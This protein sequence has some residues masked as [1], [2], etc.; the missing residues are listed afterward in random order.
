MSHPIRDHLPL[1][2]RDMVAAFG[3]LNRIPVPFTLLRPA[4]V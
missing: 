1:L 2:A 3:L 4:D